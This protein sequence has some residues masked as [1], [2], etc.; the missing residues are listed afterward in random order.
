MFINKSGYLYNYRDGECDVWVDGDSKYW[1][2]HDT[3]LFHRKGGPAIECPIS[4][5]FFIKGKRHRVG[6]PAVE[7]GDGQKQWF[8]NDKSYSEEDYEM[9]MLCS[10]IID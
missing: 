3:R 7:Y 5:H 9:I 1:Y 4:K 2:L 10:W 6:G 8:I